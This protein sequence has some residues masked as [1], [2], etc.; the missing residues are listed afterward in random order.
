[1]SKPSEEQ[2][3]GLHQHFAK[4]LPN[5]NSLITDSEAVARR[6]RIEE[7]EEKLRFELALA[8]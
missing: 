7:L 5:R 8:L 6:R 2:K 3:A 1:M 4:K